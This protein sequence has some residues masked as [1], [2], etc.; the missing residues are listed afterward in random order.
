MPLCIRDARS[1]RASHP[2]LRGDE[3]RVTARATQ[4]LPRR[5]TYVM[6]SMKDKSLHGIEADKLK[7][8]APVYVILL[9]ALGAMTFF[10]VCDPS[11]RRYGTGGGSVMGSAAT[12]DGESISRVEFARAYGSA[13]ERYQRMYQDAFDPRQLQLAHMVLRGLVDQRAMYQRAVDLGLKASDAEVI[14]LLTH[15][16][17]FK[18]E[19]GKFS[20]EVFN[21]YLDSQG[22]TEAS[23]MEEVRRNVTLQKLRRFVADTA[24]VS[25]KEAELD[26]KLQETKIDVEFLRFDPSKIDVKVEPAEIDKLLADEAGKKRVKEYYDQNPHEFNQ[27]EQV[28]ARHILVAFKG[29]RNAT[30]DAEKRTKDEAKK[31]ADE[32]AAKAQAPGADFAALATQYTDEAAGKTRGG[33][34]GFF[35]KDK[36]DKAFADA[37]WALEPGKVSGV[38]E[39]PFGFHVIKV[40]EK[41]AAVSTKLEDAQRKIAEQ[42][43]LKDKRPALAKA[44]AEKVLE[45]LKAKQPTEALLAEDKLTWSATGDVGMDAKFLPGVGSGK[46]VEDAMADLKTPGQVHNGLVDVRGTYYILRLKS[47]KDAD[48]T[49]LDK[50]KKQEL[51]MSASYSEGS[52]MYQAFEKQVRD[53][54]EKKQKIWLNPQYLAQDNASDTEGDGG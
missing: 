14:D 26:Y 50:Q 35:T 38:V 25:S 19:T 32:V 28:K 11:G 48:L 40:E 46:E 15:E 20:E 30:A 5:W 9:A 49:K 23:F 24:V 52:S 2:P 51:A 34:L 42:L 44:R 4:R 41:K 8:N 54:L 18:D 3:R 31:R 10:G 53:E 12:V 33:D 16:D 13:K 45:A 17:V 1:A 27:P 47:R 36:M 39:S 29:A 7:K 22:Y 6:W 21:R 37:A 43:L